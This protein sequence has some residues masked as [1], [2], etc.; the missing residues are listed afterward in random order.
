MTSPH[1]LCSSHTPYTLALHPLVG[2]PLGQARTAARTRWQT[3][4]RDLILR[5]QG[6]APTLTPPPTPYP[7]PLTL[8][9]TPSPSHPHPHTLT[10]T[11]TLTLSQVTRQLR[12]AH[13]QHA[14]ELQRQGHGYHYQVCGPHMDVFQPALTTIR[15]SSPHVQHAQTRPWALSES[16]CLVP[17]GA[18]PGGSEQL[19]IHMHMHMHM[20]MCM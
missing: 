18:V 17:P 12:H 20:C 1:P 15:P 13:A 5:D 2:K 9:L 10:L 19:D 14:D 7:L 11:L 8:T 3:R 16:D 6:D 4:A